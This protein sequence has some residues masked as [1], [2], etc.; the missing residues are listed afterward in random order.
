MM[1]SSRNCLYPWS[2]Q[3]AGKVLTEIPY[4]TLY[5]GL[6]LAGC[7]STVSF[8][9]ERHC[10]FGYYIPASLRERASIKNMW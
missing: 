4:E 3:F 5:F 8:G 2:P 10:D 7:V 9:T 6:S 1:L